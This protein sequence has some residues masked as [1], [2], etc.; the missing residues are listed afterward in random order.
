MTSDLADLSAKATENGQAGIVV[1][2]N[3]LGHEVRANKLP[4]LCCRRHK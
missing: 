3:F 2:N 4:R 1:C